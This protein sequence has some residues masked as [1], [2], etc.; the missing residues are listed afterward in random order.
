VVRATLES[1]D[2]H[3]ETAPIVHRDIRRQLLR[4]FPYMLFYRLIAGQAVVVGCFH[5]GRR[6]Q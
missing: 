2:A 4:R 1:I 6:G 5:A 3:P